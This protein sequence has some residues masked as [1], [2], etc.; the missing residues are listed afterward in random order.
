MTQ[1]L[2]PRIA[3]LTLP[4]TAIVRDCAGEMQAALPPFLFNHSVRSFVFAALAYQ[5]RG[6]SFDA[7]IAFVAAL[8]HDTGL[9]AAFQSAGER[10]E[11]DGADATHAFLDA[12]GVSSERSAVAWDAVA[13]HACGTIAAR[14][15]P[16]VA[17]L[18]MGTS[19]DV[20]GAGLGVL[21]RA[22]VDEV[23]RVLPRLDFKANIRAA[24]LAYA[25]SKPLAQIFTITDGLLRAHAPEAAPP[26]L[27]ALIYAAPFA[28]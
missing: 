8:M 7:E 9:V 2:P 26:S 23:V 22:V 12:R 16:E 10:F 20:A 27:E 6:T 18:A 11:I 15:A 17:M 28:Q 24:F 5:V 1:T 25:R 19:M 3:G 14:K 13:L 4:D 21:D